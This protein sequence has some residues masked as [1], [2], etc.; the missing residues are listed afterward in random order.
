M[1]TDKERKEK[2]NR[3]DKYRR[4]SR[5]KRPTTLTKFRDPLASNLCGST[6]VRAYRLGAA[7][8]RLAVCEGVLT[9]LCGPSTTTI[10][11]TTTVSTTTTTTTTSRTTVTN[12]L[13]HHRTTVYRRHKDAALP[14]VAGHEIEKKKKKKKRR[15]RR[16]RRK[17]RRKRRRSVD[18]VGSR[19]NA[20]RRIDSRSRGG[21][22]GTGFFS[23]IAFVVVA[24]ME[25][26]NGTV[27]KEEKRRNAL[28]GPSATGAVE[29][30]SEALVKCATMHLPRHHSLPLFSSHS[31]YLSFSLKLF[32]VP[33]ATRSK[34]A[35]I[36]ES[37]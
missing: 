17:R 4:S 26:W 35:I 25:G 19:R 8:R 20:T 14:A 37:P 1:G 29:P 27:G 7:L 13:P 34:R 2:K 16:R 18:C 23:N 11:T 21:V 9:G 10:T 12:I 32:P 3:R 6:Y 36:F 28:F 5:T 30:E 33:S 22:R 15:R 24:M 31:I